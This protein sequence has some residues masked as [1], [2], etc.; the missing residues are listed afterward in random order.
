[1]EA[2]LALVRE[3]PAFTF[4]LS[5]HCAWSWREGAVTRRR[6]SAPLGLLPLV[7]VLCL[8]CVGALCETVFCV[9]VCTCMSV[10]SVFSVP[11]VS[12][13]RQTAVVCTR[14]VVYGLRRFSS[15]SWFPSSLSLSGHACVC[16]CVCCC[17]CFVCVVQLQRRRGVQRRR[18]RSQEDRRQRSFHVSGV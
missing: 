5:S 9:C 1:M 12:Y 4:V 16:V 6:I 11:F 10:C 13:T 3:R 15:S 18:E 17:G 8:P 2:L 7:Y 14:S